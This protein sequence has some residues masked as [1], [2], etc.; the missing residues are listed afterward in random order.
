[1]ALMA[2]CHLI[3]HAYRKY[4]VHQLKKKTLNKLYL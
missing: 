2:G 3:Y 4:E 1:M